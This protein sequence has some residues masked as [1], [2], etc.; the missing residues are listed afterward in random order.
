VRAVAQARVARATG[1]L[2]ALA[3]L[4]A[5]AQAAPVSRAAPHDDEA[6]TV[7]DAPAPPT[8]PALTR[9]DP[10]VTFEYTAAAIAPE[11]TSGAS[12]KSAYAWFSHSEVELPLVPRKWFVGAAHDLAAASVPGVESSM[13]LGSPEVWGRGVWSSV[14]GL[15]SGGG[16]GVV[17]PLPREISPQH[18]KVLKTAR[19]V[20][21]WDE[22]YFSDFTLTFRPWFD[23]RHITGPFIF[24]FRQG[25]DWSLVLREPE[26]GEHVADIRARAAFYFGYRA[27]T[28]VGLG[29]ELWEVYQL[30]EG[31]DDGERAAFAISPSI[32]F[33][34]PRVQPAVSVLLPIA[35]PLRGDV[36][37]YYAARLN[38]GFTLPTGRRG[39]DRASR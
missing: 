33:I 2:A 19:V 22:A 29:L 21:P 17:L 1:V 20:R 15:S 9:R 4:A 26:G 13:F 25:I 39:A 28:A 37:S 36:V 5:F 3:P 30:T 24:Q 32:R 6:A 38:V 16:F 27:S 8:L 23:M 14:R 35:T 12:G 10:I 11:R 18:E 34:L 31:L 7:F